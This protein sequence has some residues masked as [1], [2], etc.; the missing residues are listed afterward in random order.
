M[1]HSTPC[2]HNPLT[3]NGPL[4]QGILVLVTLM[5][6]KTSHVRQERSLHSFKHIKV[7][8]PRLRQAA[9]KLFGHTTFKLEE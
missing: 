3:F 9:G 7:L 1:A 6:S 4:P 8:G 5:L 2:L